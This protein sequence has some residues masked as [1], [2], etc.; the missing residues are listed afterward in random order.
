MANPI[1][2]RRVELLGVRVLVERVSPNVVDEGLRRARSGRWATLAMLFA[3]GAVVGAAIAPEP[4]PG[5]RRRYTTSYLPEPPRLPSFP[6][7]R[8]LPPRRA[9]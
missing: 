6:S 9:A 3:A 8:L 2:D 1:L 4:S 5:P 7:H